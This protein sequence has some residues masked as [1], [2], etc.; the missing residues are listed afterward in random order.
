VVQRLSN[1]DLAALQAENGQK[2]WQQIC[3]AMQT[4][5]V[6]GI[7]FYTHFA[8]VM[9]KADY[10]MKRLVDGSDVLDIPGFSSLTDITLEEA[11]HDIMAGKPLTVSISMNRFWFAPGKNL[12]LENNDVVTIKECQVKLMTEKQYFDRFGEKQATGKSDPHADSFAEAF[13]AYFAKIARQRSINLELEN[14]FRFVALAKILRYRQA[15]RTADFSPAYF[16]DQYETEPAAVERQL[17][18]RSVVR[19]HQLKEEIEGG[20]RTHQLWFPSCGGVGIEIQLSNI[21]FLSDASGILYK[22]RTAVLGDRPALDAI[23]WDFSYE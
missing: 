13:T 10:D 18:G 1:M 9:V 7:P 16:L 4:V 14:L 3:G 23:Y 11:R 22:L 8:Q 6:W 12:Y 17:P 21:N 5:N 19:H 2:E 15:F 20:T